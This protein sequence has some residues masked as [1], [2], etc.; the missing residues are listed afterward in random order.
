MTH[1]RYHAFLSYNRNDEPDVRRIYEFLNDRGLKVWFDREAL[2]PGTD[3]LDEMQIGLSAS[4]TCIV[5]HRAEPGPWNQE[6]VK[7]ALRQRADNPL[8]TIIPVLLPGGASDTPKLPPFL[9]GSTWVDLRSG[10]FDIPALRKLAQAV[11]GNAS[12]PIHAVPQGQPDAR[13]LPTGYRADV[14]KIIALLIGES[15]YKHRYVSIREII[16]NAVDA[17]ER[18]LKTSFGFRPEISIIVNSDEGYFEVIDNGEGM[19]PYLLSECF[20]VI[21]KSIKDEDNI[22]ERTQSDDST[23]LFLIG[24]F[25]IGFISTYILAKKVFI[26]TTYAG[27]QQINVEIAGIADPFVYHERSLVGRATEAVGSSVRVYLKDE[28]RITGKTP[29]NVPDAVRQYC[30]H[31]ACLHT[32]K[33]AK[34]VL[35]DDWN[36]TDHRVVETIAEPY[37]FELR[38]G[39]ADGDTTFIA[40]NAG[41][42]ISDKPE[43]ITPP[44]MPT[45]IGGEINLFPNVVDLNIARD[46]I[47][48]NDKAAKIRADVSVGI[49]KLLVKAAAVSLPSTSR[50][51]VVDLLKIY[52]VEAGE[53]ELT[54][55]SRG[56]RHEMLPLSV[57]EAAD[58]LA[59]LWYLRLDGRDLQLRQA[60]QKSRAAGKNRIYWYRWYLDEPI[61]KLFKESLV[62]RGFI[63]VKADNTRVSFRGGNS[64]LT[65]T[66]SALKQLAKRFNFE[67]RGIDEPLKEDIDELLVGQERVGPILRSIIADIQ[68][69]G[70]RDVRIGRLRDAPAAFTL[71]HYDYLNLDNEVLRKVNQNARAYD[72]KTL[73]AYVLGLLQYE[74]K[75]HNTPAGRGA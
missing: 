20:A 52:I 28:F 15:L 74:L 31:V 25:G 32:P 50:K 14:G 13:G 44:L 35:T 6:E 75:G 30:R 58:L 61:V 23:R 17:C 37:L 36:V 71:A 56:V 51:A 12:V 48:D 46:A 27:D 47:I 73:R 65:D 18:R 39:L 5:F 34:S 10:L 69:S 63:V 1:V 57:A 60:L 59:E 9:K 24:K 64:Y 7:Q 19:S 70:G 22:L 49:K 16:Q 43:T 66:S 42:L 62:H 29:L 8:F 41:F 53:T 21:G 26:S 2:A 3:W 55:P 67:L 45:I 40:S 4:K 33:D 54:A 68:R 11:A 72:H 38:L